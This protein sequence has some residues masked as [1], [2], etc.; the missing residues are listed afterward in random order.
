MTAPRLWESWDL[1]CESTSVLEETSQVEAKIRWRKTKDCRQEERP[2]QPLQ[3]GQGSERP[4]GTPA[5]F[6]VSEHVQSANQCVGRRVVCR[7]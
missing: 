3:S 7:D 4:V 5:T 1:W 6:L 2:S